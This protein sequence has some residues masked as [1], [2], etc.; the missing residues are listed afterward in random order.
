MIRSIDSFVALCFCKIDMTFSNSQSSFPTF[1]SPRPYKRGYLI[2]QQSSDA[3]EDNHEDGMDFVETGAYKSKEEDEDADDESKWTFI[4]TA[5][6]FLRH[7][8]KGSGSYQSHDG[9]THHTENTLNKIGIVMLQE[10][11]ADGQ[12]QDKWQPHH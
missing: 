1:C 3:A 9:W 4:P 12:H 8:E 10:E 7:Q 11:L 6:V 2:Y 5:K